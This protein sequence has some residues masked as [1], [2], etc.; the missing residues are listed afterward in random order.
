MSSFHPMRALR[1]WIRSAPAD[2]EGLLERAELERVFQRESALAERLVRPFSMAVF[3]V[4]DRAREVEMAEALI[5]CLRLG[6]VAGRLDRERIAVMLIGADREGAWTFVDRALAKLGQR[7]LTAD[8]RVY[9]DLAE[10][11]VAGS[12]ADRARDADDDSPPNGG[13]GDGPHA[14]LLHSMP[15]EGGPAPAIPAPAREEVRSP[16]FQLLA[17]QDP[18]ERPVADLEEFRTQSMPLWKRAM[19]VSCSGAALLLLAPLL[20]LLAALVN[21]SSPGPVFFVQRRAGVGGKPFGFYKF[22]S[23][24][25][26]AEARKAELSAQNEADGPIFKIK[27]DP[28]VTPIGRVIRR[29]S[30]DEL[31]QLYN[32]LKGDMSLVGPRP[33]TLDEVESYEKWHRRRLT[34]KGGLTCTWQV[35]GRSDVSFTEWM[36]MDARYARRRN[37]G[38]DLGLILRTVRAVATGRGAY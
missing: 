38:T 33:P 20:L 3:T 29:Y 12:G 4:E 34:L 6:D 11:R 13:G 8:C 28:R 23:M 14:D 10:T 19:D 2:P 24:Y 1:R 15:T 17:S 35:S 21:L 30:L 27:N 7:R 18:A 9:V 22:R 32:V 25:V 26:D 37:L 16:S 36:R 31:P 5:A